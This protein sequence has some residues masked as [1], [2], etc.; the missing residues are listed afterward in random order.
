TPGVVLFVKSSTIGRGDD[1]LGRVLITGFI[2]T[3]SSHETPPKKIF[4]VNSGVTLTAEGSDVIDALVKLADSGVE[5][6]S[7]GTCLD[8]Y[9]LKEKLAVGKVGNMYELVDTLINEKVI[10]I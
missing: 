5:I 10:Y 7:C 8:F 9:G 1:E 4:F 6:F 2:N 3:I